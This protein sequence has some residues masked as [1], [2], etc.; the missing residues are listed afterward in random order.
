MSDFDEVD[1]PVG[2]GGWMNLF[3]FGFAGVTPIVVIVS[4]YQNPI[5]S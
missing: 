3:L 2:I 5:W 4:S 1:G